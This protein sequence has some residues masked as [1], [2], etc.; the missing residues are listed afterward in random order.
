MNKLLICTENCEYYIA[1]IYDYDCICPHSIP[2]EYKK[3]CDVAYVCI[4]KSNLSMKHRKN[5]V[6]KGQC[7]SYNILVKLPKELF[8][9]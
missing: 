2:H 7:K 1:G 4:G 3:E 6:H 5:E 8:E 9:I